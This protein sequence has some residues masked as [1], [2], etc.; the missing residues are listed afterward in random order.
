MA[1][2]GCE[3][4]M[5]ITG[6]NKTMCNKCKAEIE[7]MADGTMRE[8]CEICGGRHWRDEP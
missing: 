8:I 6:A 4:T 3:H 7:V 2:N 5:L 1:L